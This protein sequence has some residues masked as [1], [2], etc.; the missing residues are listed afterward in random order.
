MCLDISDGYRF[1]A[2]AIAGSA[3]TTLTYPLDVIRTHLSVDMTNNQ[4]IDTLEFKFSNLFRGLLPTLIATSTMV[5][6]QNMTYDKCVD[7][8]TKEFDFEP[9]VRLFMACGTFAGLT[10][11]GVIYPLDVLRRHVQI[12]G[13]TDEIELHLSK[14]FRFMPDVVRK[15][16]HLIHKQGVKTLYNGIL[17]TYLK[18]VPSIAIA[19]STRDVILGKHKKQ[20][21][22]D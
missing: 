6:V 12:Y 10:A 18:T 14:K 16:Y 7:I 20:E 21:Q 13:K 17:A 5:G 1:V 11:Q 19:M 2:G 3:A 9:S 22:D 4:K 8:A 15:G